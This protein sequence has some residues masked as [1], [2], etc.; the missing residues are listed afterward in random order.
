M[1]FEQLKNL[2]KRLEENDPSLLT[3][4]LEYE[5]LGVDGVSL[6][7]EALHHNRIVKSV[8]VQYSHIGLEGTKKLLSA[9]KG[10]GIKTRLEVRDDYTE[11]E[12]DALLEMG[13]GA[14]KEN[15]GQKENK[16]TAGEEK[17]SAQEKKESQKER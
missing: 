3:L 9:L 8:C 16:G 2:C 13:P 12:Y 14:K 1:D 17:S 5:N 10:R 6:L 7:A 15:K 11:A 4:N